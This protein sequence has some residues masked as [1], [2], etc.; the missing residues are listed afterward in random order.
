MKDFLFFFLL[1]L[2]FT[3][4]QRILPDDYKEYDD[5][6]PNDLLQGDTQEFHHIISAF[7]YGNSYVD[8]YYGLYYTPH[9]KCGPYYRGSLYSMNPG[10]LDLSST[11]LK[12]LYNKGCYYNQNMNVVFLFHE[13]ENAKN[14]FQAIIRISNPTSDAPYTFDLGTCISI[15]PT[16]NECTNFE[17]I[18]DNE[19]IT[20]EKHSIMKLVIKW[21]TKL[22]E[23]RVDDSPNTVKILNANISENFVLYFNLNQC[24]DA[25][26]KIV[27]HSIV[28][29]V[30]LHDETRAINGDQFNSCLNKG[31]INT[32]TCKPITENNKPFY[33]CEDYDWNRGGYYYPND[34][35]M[36]GC[37]ENTYCNKND[38]RCLA[39]D[40]T[41][42]TCFT[43]SNNDC[44][45]CYRNAVSDQWYINYQFTQA[46]KQM[47]KY[48]YNNMAIFDDF[49]V[50][51]P[52]PLTYRITIEFWL[53]VHDTTHLIDSN[54]RPSFSGFIIKDFFIMGVMQDEVKSNIKTIIIPFEHFFPFNKNIIS[55]EDLKNYKSKYTSLQYQESVVQN[56]SSKWIYYR[57]GVSVPQK[58]M[59]VNKEQEK[60]LKYIDFFSGE[61]TTYKSFL[62]QFYRK[63]DKTQ[64]RVQGF[65]FVDTEMYLRNLNIYSEYM[66][67]NVNYP[68]YFNLHRINNFINYPQ[69]MYVIPFDDV[70][71]DSNLLTATMTGYDFSG[72]FT[73]DDSTLYNTVIEN[74]ITVNWERITPKPPKNFKRI[75]F[76]EGGFN[77]EYTSENLDNI[78]NIDC[79]NPNLFCEVKDKAYVCQ[80]GTSLLTDP[81]GDF[82]SCS[83][84]CGDKF[85][86]PNSKINQI[87]N[88]K[89]SNNIC[90]N[91]CINTQTCPSNA[92]DDIFNFKCMKGQTFFY[93][94]LDS[95]EYPP[96]DSAIQFSGTY[97]TKSMEINLPQPLANFYIEMWIH[98][99]LLTQKIPPVYQSHL[100]M[101]DK[102]QLYF[103][104]N[105]DEYKVKITDNNL[106]TTFPLG[107]KISYYGWN[108]LIFASL[109]KLGEQLTEISV[110]VTN[111]FVSVGSVNGQTNINKLCFCNKDEN[112]CGVSNVLWMDMFIRE[113]KIWDAS[114]V[115]ENTL[116][117]FDKF[118][119]IV[120]GGLLYWF[121][122]TIDNMNNNEV[123]DKINNV[124]VTFPYD[125][126]FLNPDKDMNFNYGW[127]FNWND[128][129]RPQFITDV[130]IES[131]NKVSIVSTENCDV[132]CAMCFGSSKFTCFKCKEGYALIGST[133]TKTNTNK[134]YFYYINP[135][136]NTDK[137][138]E[139]N[140]SGIDSFP[141][142]TIAFYLKL[143]GFTDD[144]VNVNNQQNYEMITFNNNDPL[145][146]L[147]YNRAQDKIQLI[148]GNQ[149]LFEYEN[150]LSHFGNWIHIS[151]SRFNA[152]NT[153]LQNNMISMTVNLTPLDYIGDVNYVY[154]SLPYQ[155]FKLSKGM[156]AEVAEVTFYNIF[157]LN[158]YGYSQHKM[159]PTQDSIFAYGSSYIIKAFHL[160]TSDE[161]TKE[162]VSLTD[163]NININILPSMI[164]CVEDY[165]PYEDQECKDDQ[166][167][168][169][170]SYYL[171]PQCVNSASKC[172]NIV[173]TIKV[174]DN[175]DYL[176][177]TCDNISKNSINNLIFAYTPISTSKKYII[178]G[179]SITMDMAR[180]QSGSIPN[181]QNPTEE[182]KLEFWFI[183]Q[184]YVDINFG[185]FTADWSDH[186][187]IKVGYNKATNKFY[188]QCNVLGQA[189][190]QL[191]FEYEEDIVEEN[192]WRYVVCGINV[193][194]G[195][196]YLTNLQKQ[197]KKEGTNA[198]GGTFGTQATLQI[199]ED[200][201]TN[202]G[203]TYIKE[204]RLWKCYDCAADRAFVP[205]NKDDPFFI[206][207]TNY[208]KFENVTG[209][210]TD[211]RTKPSTGDPN[212]S[213]QLL[214]KGDFNGYGLLN[215]IPDLPN[216]N[217]GGSSYFSLKNGKGCDIMFNFNVFKEDIVFD[218]VPASKSNKYTMDMWFYVE[219]SD[220]F[221]KGFNLIYD[222]HMTISAY[223][224]NANDKN[225]L[226]YCFPQA[227][228]DNLFNV[229][230]DDIDILYNTKAVNKVK[231]EYTD[232][233][234]KWN[235]VRCAYSFDLQKYYMN[236][237]EENVIPEQF[238]GSPSA[239]SNYKS[240]K[241][242]MNSYVKVIING[243]IDNFTRIFI[244]TI[245]I[246]RD[247]IP[248][249]IDL[250]YLSMK[251]Y[252]YKITGSEYYPLLFTVDFQNDYDIIQNRL[253]YYI[254][255]FD[256]LPDY[257]LYLNG[258][259][260]N[261]QARSYLTYP[262]YD[263]F[264]QCG[265]SK[266]YDTTT[267]QCEFITSPVNCDNQKV[268]CLENDKFFWC[269]KGEYLDIN[270]LQCNS[271]CPT[272]YTRPSDIIDGYGMCYIKA[273]EMNYE[274]YPY[275]KA[276]LSQLNYQNSFEC[277]PG[278]LFV[279]YHCIP[280]SLN[281]NS[282]VYFSNKY[283]FNNMVANYASLYVKN[284]FVD[285]WFMFDNIEQYRFNP[286]DKER[287]YIFIAYPHF[288]SRFHNEIQ[289]TNS[290]IPLDTYTIN[291]LNQYNWNHIVIENYVVEGTTISDTFKYINV[292]VNNNYIT[293]EVSIKTG[294]TNDFSLSQIAFCHKENSEYSKCNLGLNSFSY[295][296]YE[297][298][299][300]DAYYRDITVWNW[301]TT[302][303]PSITSFNSNK[304]K[305]LTMNIISYH[306]LTLNSIHLSSL[307]SLT[308]YKTKRVNFEAKMNTQNEYDKSQCVNWFTNF[309]M[310]YP[311][312]SYDSIRTS[313]TALD[314][315]FS[316]SSTEY[317][318]NQCPPNCE[319]CFS[320]DPHNCISCI[321]HY[322]LTGTECVSI[323]NYYFKTPMD[324]NDQFENIDLNFDLDYNIYK[325]I[326]IMFYMKFMGTVIDKVGIAPV[327]YFYNKENYL[328]WNND[329]D[330]FEI[331]YNNDQIAFEYKDSRA[332]I[333]KWALYAI[334]ISHSSYP[335]KF[336]YMIQFMIDR[337]MIHPTKTF[338]SLM[339]TTQI[340]YNHISLSNKVSAYYHDLRIYRKFFIGAYALGQDPDTNNHN[341]LIYNLLLVSSTDDDTCLQ[342]INIDTTTSQLGTHYCK[343]DDNKYD[344][345]IFI[346]QNPPEQYRVIDSIE[347]THS[348]NICD[349]DYCNSKCFDITTKGCLCTYDS[350]I[351]WLRNIKDD[352]IYCERPNSLNLN[353]YG[354]IIVSDINGGTSSYMIE[355]WMFIYSYISNENFKG[356]DI[357]WDKYIR[358][359]IENN[360]GLKIKCYPYSDV[361]DY[362]IYTQYAT[363]NTM[364]FNTWTFIRCVV[365]KAYTTIT[366][367]GNNKIYTNSIPSQPSST[368]LIIRTKDYNTPEPYGLVLLRELRLWSEKNNL[369][370]DTARL[371]LA[372]DHTYTNLIHYFKNIYHTSIND[373]SRNY[374]YDEKTKKKTTFT[375]S[376]SPY[377]YS[378]ID[379]SLIELVLC[380]EG[381]V[382]KL[383]KIT[384]QYEC[385]LY[386]SDDILNNVQDD[387]TTYTP[388]DLLSKTKIL[389]ETALNDYE[390]PSM[391]SN[392]YTEMS[393]DS[394]GNILINDPVTSNA[395]CCNKGYAKIVDH[396]LTCYCFSDYVGKYCQLSNE[397]YANIDEIYM[398]FMEKTINTYA[399]YIDDSNEK[400]KLISSLEYLIDGSGL[401]SIDNAFIS[402]VTNWFNSDVIY[403]VT[404]CDLDYIRLTDKLYGNN[405]GLTNHYKVGVMTNTDGRNTDRNGQLNYLQTDEIKANAMTLKKLL[406]YLTSLCFNDL[407]DSNYQWNYKSENLNVDLIR[408]ESSLNLTKILENEKKSTY[409]P[410]ISIENCQSGLYGK[411][412]TLN[413]QYITWY[414][415]PYYYDS[416]L[417]WNYTSHHIT[418]KL[419][420]EKIETVSSDE[421]SDKFKFYLS[422]YNPTFVDVI[423]NNKFHFINMYDS[424][425]KIFTEPKF[426]ESNG[427]I[428]NLTREERINLYYFEYLLEFNSIDGKT[429]NYTTSGLSYENITSDNYIIGASTHL[430]EFIMN[431]KY[432]P[433]PDKVDGKFYFLKHASIYFNLTNYTSNYGFFMIM[434]I[435]GMY[436][437]NFMVCFLKLKCKLK[438]ADGKRYRLILDFLNEYVYP[439]E[440]TEGE[441]I[442]KQNNGNKI[443]NE[444]LKTEENNE[445]V[446]EKQTSLSSL[447]VSNKTPPPANEV[448]TLNNL[449]KIPVGDIYDKKKFDTVFSRMADDIIV[450]STDTARASK[451]T[452]ITNTTNSQLSKTN[453]RILIKKNKAK[454][455]TSTLRDQPIIEEEN[456]EE[457][458]ENK[459][460]TTSR[461]RNT[462]VQV[463]AYN[464]NF[465]I[466]E[467]KKFE[468]EMNTEDILINDN[469][470]HNLN[471]YNEDMRI[472]SFAKMKTNPCKFFCLNFINRNLFIC[473]F[474]EN[475]TYTAVIKALYLPMYLS[476]NLFINT[477]IY[478]FNDNMTYDNLFSEHLVK[479]ILF[480]LITMISCNAYFYIKS[481]I[482][483]IDKNHIRQ[484]LYK[485]KT[486]KKQ[487][488]SD[489]I[490]VIKR[491]KIGYIIETILFFLFT[492]ITLIFSFGLCAI[493]NEQGKCMFIS[494][495]ATIICDFILE[496]IIEFIIMLLY[497]CRCNEVLVIVLDYVNRIKSYKVLSP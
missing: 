416:E 441:F 104:T 310:T 225:I 175:C 32:D 154:P 491:N 170:S 263:D 367:N 165:L 214:E 270:S 18:L 396:T 111:T 148:Y 16:T 197:N 117:D 229:K 279:N 198:I 387:D 304:Q 349:G 467:N 45:S 136:K 444:D 485:F 249:T 338:S 238:F 463:D 274:K 295:K 478:L 365:D 257:E 322:V 385:S 219:N 403:K 5:Y 489:Y 329:N 85:H 449:P 357:I 446:K 144:V 209:N 282:G 305:D 390:I 450:P 277:K 355:C 103:D 309:D 168:Q 260:T 211:Y 423:K 353:E 291:N 67:N 216:C 281:D 66:L 285:F 407:N 344:N 193:A 408:M 233:F 402:K 46:N 59:F 361:N 273:D 443:Y 220:D 156:I 276:A 88:K 133:C 297:P 120:I 394:E 221:T 78:R 334:S 167:V 127:N 343:G 368:Q 429:M 205:Y 72:Q 280:V 105:D 378:Y 327:V 15:N 142:I 43:D 35:S 224:K 490:K 112:C 124:Q 4:T 420:N 141:S 369:F 339:S 488:D 452:D 1:L 323:T 226:V 102:H 83:Y 106:I 319:R 31:C 237:Q 421:C 459:P 301:N 328:S 256:Y 426:I 129:N 75:K 448:L 346:C 181:I 208:F 483:Y 439:Y 388:S 194:S 298:L 185:S 179:Q 401:Y 19:Y 33:F 201:P 356:V 414:N 405:I 364:K 122:F 126:Y 427:K 212:V 399:K 146:Q 62:R 386:G 418:I 108:H 152:P 93:Q 28:L 242:F 55:V 123:Y 184:S 266:Y 143:Y 445:K 487:F 91:Q 162:C 150:M 409:E 153:S 101:T 345:G 458:D 37:I 284:Y 268:F 311:N 307:L 352:T 235:Y 317:I 278:Y 138:F 172:D 430:S 187:K 374:I 230:G 287:Y 207:V 13:N 482:Y 121:P 11:N 82:D 30:N 14:D 12:G 269:K 332:S 139:L 377:P 354:N 316:L 303:I 89:I 49:E 47:C 383:N 115:N 451:P 22:T 424:N 360:N 380:E 472:T 432:N 84:S 370:Y 296:I 40:L 107:Q 292:Y 77:N 486:S 366:L 318:I 3:I 110:S 42:R 164:E 51:I 410:Y 425:D 474:R 204:M 94:C 128:N 64:L 434:V 186:I 196:Y 271:D 412:K 41:C 351:Y 299:W 20:I 118:T 461:K 251:K 183:T 422:V 325:E 159:S 347:N 471:I 492:F 330:S 90:G 302:N 131:E 222:K 61:T 130:Q 125:K 71:I 157:I 404:T 375:P 239:E 134:G 265:I 324:N 202:F 312:Y 65:S 455:L 283:M 457:E 447:T 468:E 411:S 250:R 228:R 258:F 57:G 376:L 178:C 314:A 326:T 392:V 358:I 70:V 350:T 359:E 495:I 395:F 440:N 27:L 435:V 151:I 453:D 155:T 477:F 290:F 313:Y 252:A 21:N 34:C 24:D 415:S 315:F 60:E 254:T 253:K 419:Y 86:L 389:Y 293:P 166:F 147:L 248:K 442:F 400:A 255:D 480:V 227:Y 261:V 417:Y 8:E 80:S 433:Y 460:K 173:Q 137:E 145:Y 473:S 95:F 188:A 272:G 92:Y 300:E 149:V 163:V 114:I 195:D 231:E 200:S 493:Y 288:I 191:Y 320:N 215:S 69:L 190:N 182:F 391:I 7:S 456:I 26:G 10:D 470:K 462:N 25:N 246:Y 203:V 232:A 140:C 171:P 217:E 53:F 464:N 497:M 247:Y 244:Q 363:D 116:F 213:V 241:Y 76:L 336:P 23:V 158:A 438:K 479:F 372:T 437:V 431:Y 74:T 218:K 58:K 54:I 475:A 267:K 6:F 100:L 234:S 436:V 29:M 379:E 38:K 243:A 63:G 466:I 308:T 245:N 494:F 109:T 174:M 381:Y 2:S 259:M 160:R 481:L 321:D 189:A 341:Y 484:L 454:P 382:Y 9:I 406:E 192:K 275:L 413:V 306:P 333:G 36:D 286:D 98:P 337:V 465:L 169:I 97:N 236:N 373:E 398:Y 340:K 331:V 96:E 469:Y 132:G 56:P 476:L 52:I 48:E 180:Y 348:C 68:N 113:L 73:Y 294:R 393:I 135:L 496:I 384:N 161:V 362:D 79:T 335:D 99:D 428:N 81:N 240:L 223:V 262:V 44:R 264:I 289:Y 17:S 87:A 206:N 397:D 210:V 119:H 50:N 177:A 342:N 199:S 176:Y 371:N 39:C